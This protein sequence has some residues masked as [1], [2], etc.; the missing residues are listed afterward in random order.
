[1]NTVK[2]ED[3]ARELNLSVST[4]SRAISGKGRVGD[5]TRARVQAAVRESGYRI[6]D[7]ARSLRMQKAQ[8]MGIIVPDI[9]NAFFASV[10]KG[11]QQRCQENGYTLFVCNSD[12]N[13]DIEAGTLEMLLSKQ[14]SGLVLASVR[15]REAIIGQ[16]GS[17]GIPIVYIDNIPQGADLCD[18]VSIDNYAASMRLTLAMIDRGYRELCMI[19][20]PQSQSSGYLRKKGFEAALAE[21]G[22]PVRPE[23]LRVGTFTMDSGYQLM[24]QLLLSDRRPRAMLFANNAIA[25]GAM[26]ALREAGLSV[27]GEMAIAA[28]DAKD[29]TGLIQPLITSLNQPAQQIGARAIETVI[30]RLKRDEPIV[31]PQLLEPSFIEGDSW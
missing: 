14:V 25:Y 4:V 30:R 29:E 16:Y 5:R 31:S 7:V 6:N 8:N 11:A 22:L 19:T 1:M 24:G 12:E 20:G 18:C 9:S 3:I 28:F 23:W 15:E 2:L 26:R 13:P 17:L 10:V 27:P 21:R